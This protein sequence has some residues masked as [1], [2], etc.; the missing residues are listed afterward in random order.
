M[1]TAFGFSEDDILSVAQRR[2]MEM[3]EEQASKWFDR[4]NHDAIE[5]AALEGLEMDEQTDLA[6]DAIES[7]LDELGCFD[8][9]KAE[10]AAEALSSATPQ[11]TATR[12]KRM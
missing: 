5:M 8:A 10:A 1:G 7:Q 4:L 12:A 3:S 9:K 6:M 11:A 2:G